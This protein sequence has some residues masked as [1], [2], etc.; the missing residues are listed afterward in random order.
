MLEVGLGAKV[1]ASEEGCMTE[2]GRG[3]VK[4]GTLTSHTP[5][6]TIAGVS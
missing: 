3:R 5:K 6:G 2:Q 4:Y 1:C